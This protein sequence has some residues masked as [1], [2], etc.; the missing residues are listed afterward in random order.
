MEG[1]SASIIS[2]E[3]EEVKV[4]EERREGEERVCGLFEE[5]FEVLDV[6]RVVVPE[7][8]HVILPGNKSVSWVICG[9]SHTT[10]K[11]GSLGLEGFTSNALRSVCDDPREGVRLSASTCRRDVLLVDLIV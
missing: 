6:G 9:C 10:L 2:P 11:D 3:D 1:M 4:L 8:A 5:L 7:P